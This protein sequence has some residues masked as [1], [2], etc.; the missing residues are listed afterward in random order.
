MRT[1][2]LC[3]VLATTAA[4]LAGLTAATPRPVRTPD[5]TPSATTVTVYGRDGSFGATPDV[6]PSGQSLTRRAVPGWSFP[7]GLRAYRTAVS[8]DGTVFMAGLGY[9]WL[10]E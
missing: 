4:V 3:G 1:R 8:G 2:R 6:L 10:R 9:N 5:A 7:P